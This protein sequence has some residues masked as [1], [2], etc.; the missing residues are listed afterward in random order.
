MTVSKRQA[1]KEQRQ[2]RKRR[3]RIT[4]LM[5]GGVV[6]LM[7]AA[8]IAGP[9]IAKSFQAPVERPM[10][11]G[12]T[13]GDADAAVLVEVFTDYQCPACKRYAETTEKSLIESGYIEQGLVYYIFRQFPFIDDY[14]GTGE[15]DQSANASMCASEQGYFWEYHDIVYANWNGENA[16][17]YSDANL[18]AFAAQLPLDMDAF[19]QCF[20]E[21]RYKSEIEADLA[22]GMQ[23]GVNGTPSVFVN[24]T[25]VAPGY[26]PT[27]EQVDEAIQAAL[28]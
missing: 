12:R 16:G 1:I 22:L 25:Q 19:E 18:L 13:L 17:T 7:M 10:A 11:D 26:I 3:Q 8:I 14:A 2:R 21:N 20:K 27:F 23:Y 6:I 24:G 15:S 28:Q 4:M 9:S 5:I